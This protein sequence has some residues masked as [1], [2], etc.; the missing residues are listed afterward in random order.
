MRAVRNSQHTGPRIIN[1]ETFSEVWNIWRLHSNRK[2]HDAQLN[3]ESTLGL[4]PYKGIEVGQRA[5]RTLCVVV[6]LTNYRARSP[7]MGLIRQFTLW[8]PKTPYEAITLT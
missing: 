4:R 8:L 6:L 5:I 3:A 7:L 2:G 1:A